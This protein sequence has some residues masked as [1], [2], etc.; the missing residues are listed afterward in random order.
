MWP[1]VAAL[2]GG[3]ILLAWGANRLVFGASAVA[4]ALGVPPLLIGLSVVGLGSASPVLLVA[5]VASWHGNAA[6]ALGTAVGSSITNIALV[7]GA[8]ALVRPLEVNSR[9]LRWEMP[10]LL[11]AMLIS[12]MLMIDF[13]LDLSD[14]LMLWSGLLL[15]MACLLS[16]GHHSTTADEPMTREFA[17]EMPPAMPVARALAWLAGGLV[18]A[19]TAAVL[20][21]WSGIELARMAVISDTVL[22]LTVIAFGSCLPLLVISI[23]G[24]LR[25][26]YDIVVG[27][28]L[29]ATMFNLLAVLAVPGMA[30]PA[31]VDPDLVTYYYPVMM[32]LAAVVW[33]MASGGRGAGAG[34]ISRIGGLGVL[35]IYA[36]YLL[37]LYRITLQ[38]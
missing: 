12:L 29:T 25:K 23:T 6:L 28:V 8:A 5:V 22:G 1:A 36:G 37:F 15:I 17:A 3:F 34:R 18:M 13:S 16:V 9:L 21:V 19:L 20:V 32:S 31:D 33:L 27:N 2:C 4:R 24:V 11:V 26:E 14:G 38:A 35:A 30:G 10:L 7:L